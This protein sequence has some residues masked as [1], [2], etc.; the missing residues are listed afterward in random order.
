MNYVWG[1]VKL[2]A[3]DINSGNVTVGLPFIATI[4]SAKTASLL[5]SRTCTKDE[6]PGRTSP[7]ALLW[8]ARGFPGDVDTIR[9]GRPPPNDACKIA[10]GL[11]RDKHQQKNGR[12]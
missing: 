9:T 3:Y 4:E 10:R 1:H 11:A 12:G 8:R 2:T 5:N 7:V 6:P